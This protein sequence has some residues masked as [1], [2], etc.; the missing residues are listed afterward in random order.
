MLL[1]LTGFIL[2]KEYIPL[3]LRYIK[4]LSFIKGLELSKNWA[5]GGSSPLKAFIL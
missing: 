2:I 5:Q 1:V 4:V 3:R